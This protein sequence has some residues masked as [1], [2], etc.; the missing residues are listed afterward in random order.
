MQRYATPPTGSPQ[1]SAAWGVVPF[2]FWGFGGLFSGTALLRQGSAFRVSLPYET[3]CVSVP[4]A[5]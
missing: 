4:P 1:G 2:C 5:V 3:A